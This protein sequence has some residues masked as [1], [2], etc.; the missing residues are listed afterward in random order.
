MCLAGQKGRAREQSGLSG[1]LFAIY[2]GG[3][4]EDTQPCDLLG[5]RHCPSRLTIPLT[6]AQAPAFDASAGRPLPKPYSAKFVVGHS[7]TGAASRAFTSTAMTPGGWHGLRLG[8]GH[9]RRPVRR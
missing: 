3:E 2:G 1:A 6:P 9:G 4:S 8:S 5:V 7:T